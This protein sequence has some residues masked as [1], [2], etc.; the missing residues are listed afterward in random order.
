VCEKVAYL[1]NLDT[2]TS[3]TAGM[4]HDI[5]RLALMW[6]CPL[7][8]DSLSLKAQKP[9][10]DLLRSERSVF[11]IDHCQAGRW[12]LENWDFPEELRH[13][14]SMHHNLPGPGASGLVRCVH[15]GWQIA[16]LIGF[17]VLNR[18][19]RGD[20]GAITAVLPPNA[21][22]AIIGQLADLSEHVALKIN[23]IECSLM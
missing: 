14:A 3:Y 7:E 20:I 2:D 6:A 23:A 18:S 21:A 15:V 17:S 22:D 16:D 1:F 13:V 5:G 10:F 12:I 9:G 8:Y 4:L 19:E 11:E